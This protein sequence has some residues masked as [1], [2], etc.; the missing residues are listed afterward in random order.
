[1]PLTKDTDRR[2]TL[3]THRI[4]RRRIR[5]PGAH[6]WAARHKLPTAAT[7]AMARQQRSRSRGYNG[8]SWV[9]GWP[10]GYNRRSRLSGRPADSDPTALRPALGRCH[11]GYICLPWLTI[12]HHGCS[13]L[14][15][16]T[17][18]TGPADPKHTHSAQES[19][20]T[21]VLTFQQ[22]Y[23]NELCYQVIHKC[24]PCIYGVSLSAFH[25]Q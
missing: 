20:P 18:Q 2:N 19:P 23:H 21:A 6:S 3:L 7:P 24:F 22:Q 8:R 5:H 13:S 17:A 15:R 11:H 9:M 4:Q 14:R 10:A 16:L 1:M 12:C 25:V